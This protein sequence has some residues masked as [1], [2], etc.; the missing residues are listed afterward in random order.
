MTPSITQSNVLAAL[1]SFLIAVLPTVGSDGKPISVLAAQQNRVPEPSGADFVILTPVRRPR[2]ETNI[3]SYADAKF[4]GSISGST[5]TIIYVYPQFTGEIGVGSTIFG[6]GVA[7]NTTVSALGPNTSGGIGTYTINPPQSVGSTTLSAGTESI[8]QPTEMVIQIDA[9]SANV[10]DSGDMIQTISTLARDEF[11]TSFFAELDPPLNSVVPLH[12]DD[13]AQRP[14]YNTAE[15]TWE[16]RWVV[17]FHLQA[18]PVISVPTEF[19][20]TIA[21]ELVDVDVVFPAG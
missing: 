20:D 16:T 21:V 10:L 11:A 5:M 3:D 19:A 4:T 1:R 9:H 13:P 14:F 18:N 15:N 7:S 8:E 17:D 6:V 2:I 12:C